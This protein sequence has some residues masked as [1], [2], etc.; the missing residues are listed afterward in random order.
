M[1]HVPAS[2]GRR[3]FV[4]SPSLA[5]DTLAGKV[6]AACEPLPIRVLT[7]LLV[8]DDRSMRMNVADMLQDAGHVVVAAG[9]AAADEA[10]PAAP[11]V[12]LV[13]NAWSPHGP[14]PISPGRSDETGVSKDTPGGE[15]RGQPPKAFRSSLSNSAGASICGAWP[16]SGNSTSFAPGISAAAALPS[17][18]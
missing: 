7:I 16:S 6:A 9:P 3:K 4:A 15:R 5:V 8:E 1:R 13:K 17:F 2:Q 11:D 10:A 12:S 18:G 14:R